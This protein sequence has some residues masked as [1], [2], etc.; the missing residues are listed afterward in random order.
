MTARDCKVMAL[1][2]RDCKTEMGSVFIQTNAISKRKKIAIPDLRQMK[3][4]SKG[5]QMT[6]NFNRFFLDS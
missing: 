5:F 2:H 3:V 6:Q 4:L 1:L